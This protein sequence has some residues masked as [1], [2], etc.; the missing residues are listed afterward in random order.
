MRMKQVIDKIYA[1]GE[2]TG[3]SGAIHKLHSEIDSQ[4]G[5]FL[6]RIIEK[7][8]SVI[9]T[10]EIG[11]GYGFRRCTF[12]RRSAGG[13]ARR[14]RSSILFKTR[15]GTASARKIWRTPGSISSSLSR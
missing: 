2:V 14:T 15:S 5:K 6:Y 12:A 4:E 3:R 7:D 11:C 13:P 9:R 8:P 10:L 1:A